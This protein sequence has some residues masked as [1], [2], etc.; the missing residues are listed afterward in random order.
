MNPYGVLLL[1]S[2]RGRCTHN[3]R[4][5]RMWQICQTSRLGE[6]LTRENTF[7]FHLF[8]VAAFVFHASRRRQRLSSIMRVNGCDYVDSVLRRSDVKLIAPKARCI[9]LQRR[10]KDRKDQWESIDQSRI[11]IIFRS[12][13]SRGRSFILAVPPIND[14]FSRDILPAYCRKTRSW[15]HSNF[16]WSLEGVPDPP[17]VTF[18]NWSPLGATL[19]LFV[20]HFCTFR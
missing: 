11:K 8:I 2:C 18:S 14:N 12:F 3:R 19:Y 15:V 10:L 9:Y 16:G 13:T 5:T 4:I 17:I 6:H 20:F 1:F 7:F